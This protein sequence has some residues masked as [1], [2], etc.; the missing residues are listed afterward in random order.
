MPFWVSAEER[1]YVLSCVE[2][3]AT[4]GHEFL[5][6]YRYNHKTGEWAHTTRLTK[7]P[8]RKWLGKFDMFGSTEG[9]DGSPSVDTKIAE[10][11]EGERTGSFSQ[12]DLPAYFATAMATAE[13][14]LSAL[15]G[16]SRGGT[17][18][19]ANESLG[20]WDHLRWF[21]LGSEVSRLREMQAS[22][23]PLVGP[24]Q[25]SDDIALAIEAYEGQDRAAAGSDHSAYRD[26]QDQKLS[27]KRGGGWALPQY[28]KNVNIVGSSSVATFSS[29]SSSSSSSSRSSEEK[30]ADTAS[31]PVS[32]AS[33]EAPEPVPTVS[34]SSEMEL[35]PDCPDGKCLLPVKRNLPGEAEK[36]P[37]VPVQPPKKMMRSVG[38]CMQDWSMIQDGDRLMLG[39]SGGKDSLSLLHVLLAL[40]KKAPV[41]FELACCTIDPQT[42]SF[43]PSP[44]I[45][46]VRGLGVPYYYISKPIIEMA[47]SKLQGDS[48]CA[49]CSRFKR[50]LLYTCCR[51]NKYNK[52]VLAQHLDDLGES[53][54]MSAL[55]NGQL[56]TMKAKYT[57]DAGDLEVIRP[58]CYLRESVARDFA[59]GSSLP[60]ISENCP[61]C[62]EE[63][64]ERARVKQ[65]LSQEESMVPGLF[66]NMRKA[67][68]PL[69]HEDSYQVMDRIAQDIEAKTGKKRTPPARGK[70]DGAAAKKMKGAGQEVKSE[71]AV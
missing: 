5:P 7:F 2:F 71:T 48:L 11:A 9:K 12:A 37:V 8:E 59:K 31:V 26:K 50:G 1:E 13:E 44:L 53:F 32:P 56:R 57:I 20:K 38:Q 49:F 51:E 35:D 34:S 47:S 69:M 6:S 19:A 68:L 29:S 27:A 21:V 61:A 43:D 22:V 55:H 65:L 17:A 3:V 18:A 54:I 41:K 62:F 66:S 28:L 4:Y 23:T 10:R 52:L 63:P 24:L 14:E 39:L 40:Q 45:P 67:L 60:V 33:K 42:A 16:P 25:P 30:V 15:R 64:K 46:Y 70:G 36:L 58:F